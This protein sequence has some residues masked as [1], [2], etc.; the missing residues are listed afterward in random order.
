[1]KKTKKTYEDLP[2]EEGKTYKTKFSTGWEFTVKKI[3]KKGDKI[4]GLEGIYSNSPDLGLCPL[5]PGRLIPERKE[6]GEIE[7]CGKCGEP[8]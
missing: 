7:V 6:V 5:D 1:V 8:L 2:F 4:T 3:R